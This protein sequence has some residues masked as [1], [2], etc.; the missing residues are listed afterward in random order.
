LKETCVLAAECCKLVTNEEN[1]RDS[2]GLSPREE[3]FMAEAEGNMVT[4]F[5]T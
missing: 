4:L 3:T 2:L 1:P 5:L